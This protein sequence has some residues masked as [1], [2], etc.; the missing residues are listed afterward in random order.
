MRAY[1]ALEKPLA[2]T[3]FYLRRYC[4]IILHGIVIKLY[5]NIYLLCRHAYA[6]FRVS[7]PSRCVDIARKKMGAKICPPAAGA[8]A[9]AAG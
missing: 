6:K 9:Q 4:D 8:E 7:S 1:N 3:S 5:H 2:D